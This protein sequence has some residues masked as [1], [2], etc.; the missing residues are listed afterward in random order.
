MEVGDVEPAALY[1]YRVFVGFVALA[2]VD[3]VAAEIEYNFAFSSL[4]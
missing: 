1:A 3:V 4:V 2:V